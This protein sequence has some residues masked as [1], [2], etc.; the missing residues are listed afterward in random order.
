RKGTRVLPASRARGGGPRADLRAGDGRSRDRRGRLRPRRGGAHGPRPPATP[1]SRARGPGPRPRAS[2]PSAAAYARA[3]RRP[4]A[5]CVSTMAFDRPF[6]LEVFFRE[7]EFA[8]PHAFSA[9]DCETIGMSD[10]LAMADADSRE[11]WESLR[12]GYTET[13]GHPV[14]REQ[15]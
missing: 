14:L 13:P 4:A 15:I 9:S 7:H 10:L 6:A 12:L 11:R 8:V 2:G 1:P 3:R 5:K